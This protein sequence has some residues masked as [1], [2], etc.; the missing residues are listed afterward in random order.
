M[1]FLRILMIPQKLNK[2]V[3]QLLIDESNCLARFWWL[4]NAL[5][6]RNHESNVLRFRCILL[7]F[8]YSERLYLQNAECKQ[9]VINGPDVLCCT[10][11]KSRVICVIYSVFVASNVLQRTD[12]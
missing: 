1:F 2:V 7:N 6:T 5:N 12:A 10:K 3:R 11:V 4:E 8:E 9:A